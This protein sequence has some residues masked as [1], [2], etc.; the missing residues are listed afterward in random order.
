MKQNNNNTSHLAERS[1]LSRITELIE[2]AR[3][4]VSNIANVTLVYTY[5]EIGHLIVEEEQGGLS[6]AQYGKELLKTLSEKL[7][8]RFGKGWS[9]ETLRVDSPLA[10]IIVV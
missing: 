2:T 10:Q 7:S 9:V 5:Y 4:K 8:E 6:R 3:R 1:L